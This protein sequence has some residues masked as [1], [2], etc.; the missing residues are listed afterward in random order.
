MWPSV[1]HG[2]CGVNVSLREIELAPGIIA[3]NVREIHNDRDP[4]YPV[5]LCVAE[6]DGKRVAIVVE[7]SHD[8]ARVIA[9]GPEPWKLTLRRAA[10]LLE[11]P[12]G[13]IVEWCRARGVEL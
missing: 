13:K 10:G 8:R 3:T 12:R 7:P 2:F 1:D 11:V 9:D 5:D 4:G 6:L